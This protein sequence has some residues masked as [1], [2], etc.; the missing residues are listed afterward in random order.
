MSS[1]NFLAIVRHRPMNRLPLY[2]SRSRLTSAFTTCLLLVAREGSFCGFCLPRE[3]CLR[4]FISN[5]YG[6]MTLRF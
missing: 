4:T 1:S 5:V 2:L 6:V 3:M